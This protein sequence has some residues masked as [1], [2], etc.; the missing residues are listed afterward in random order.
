[1]S[2]R[3]FE[4]MPEYDPDDPAAV[5]R[6]LRRQER[7]ARRKHG[8]SS[9]SHAPEP[10]G[11]GRHP[12]PGPDDGSVL[13]SDS[14][15]G[16]RRGRGAGRRGRGRTSR[17]S[18]S[19][20]MRRDRLILLG[21]IVVAALLGIWFLFAL[22]QPFAGD[23]KGETVAVKIPA[24]SGVGEIGDLLVD[25]GVI[26]NATLFEIRTTI[27]GRRS[28]LFA[29]NHVF[30]EG[31]SYSAALDELARK[32]QKEVLTVVLPEGL[33][34]SEAA[35]TVSDSG[36]PGDYMKASVRSKLLDPDDYGA[37]G[38]AESLEGFLFPATYEL[39]PGSDV[40]DLVDQQ[41]GAFK[42]NIAGVDMKYARSKNLNVYDVLTIASMVEREVSIAKERPIVSAVIY[43]RL[44]RGEPLFIDATTR[45][46]L[47]NWTE[48]LTE[49]DLAVDSPYNTR[50]NA[51]LPPGPIGSPGLAS[52]EAAAR[53]ARTDVWLYVVKPGT[54]GE[55]TFSSS[56]EEHNANVAKYQAAQEAA[57]GSPTD[58]G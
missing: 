2:E 38:R 41:L 23:P 55:H 16:I 39:K 36:L 46:A 14:G 11:A 52:I 33:S 17:L 57:G 8:G 28:E 45:F 26:S 13:G 43:N 58:C 31:M 5:E 32:P 48:P 1:M 40:H 3:W 22:F 49:S 10:A 42:D 44:S 30:R 7:L 54:C 20:G 47:D 37:Q 12:G 6:E 51:G 53:P 9:D 35:E 34:R 19:G 27:G 56:L 50:T 21:A 15:A 25:K 29:G 24:G 18:G 4:D